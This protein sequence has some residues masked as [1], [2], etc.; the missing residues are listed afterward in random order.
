MASAAPIGQAQVGCPI[1]SVRVRNRWTSRSRHST[2]TKSGRASASIGTVLFRL[3]SRKR[4]TG[5]N[6]ESSAPSPVASRARHRKTIVRSGRRRG[7]TRAWWLNLALLT[8]GHA[9]TAA[10]AV[11]GNRNPARS[12]DCPRDNRRDGD[13]ADQ[14]PFTLF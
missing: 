9:W 4:P 7:E 3:W 10:A 5:E 6:G 14:V 12:G 8:F 1:V 2:I 13:V 11:A